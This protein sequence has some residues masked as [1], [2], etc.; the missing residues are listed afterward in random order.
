MKRC[1][2]GNHPAPVENFR[3]VVRNGHP[4]IDSWCRDCRRRSNAENAA[5]GVYL[6]PVPGP[7]IH[8]SRVHW[9]GMPLTGR[10]AAKRRRIH[11]VND[12][13]L[14]PSATLVQPGHP[15]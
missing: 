15:R 6:K 10:P 12:N 2:Y 4:W 3:A 7:G 5:A 13:G 11:G 8:A 9:I 14:T 1:T